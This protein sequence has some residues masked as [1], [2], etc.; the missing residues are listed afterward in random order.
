M[1][2]RVRCPGPGSGTQRRLAD[3]PVHRRLKF[4]EGE[5]G[6]ASA[7]AQHGGVVRNVEAGSR[8]RVFRRVSSGSSAPVE[9]LAVGARASVRP[10]RGGRRRRGIGDAQRRL[11]LLVGS[12]PG[13]GA[14]SGWPCSST[15]NPSSCASRAGPAPRAEA[16]RRCRE[17]RLPSGQL[18]ATRLR[19]GRPR[20]S[21]GCGSNVPLRGGSLTVTDVERDPRYDAE[22]GAWTVVPPERRSVA[23]PSAPFV[24]RVVGARRPATKDSR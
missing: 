22:G 14:T 11:A 6:P 18:A 17:V 13:R 8:R 16:G 19:T 9:V 4:P 23:G 1:A 12:G 5:H 7:L 21:A 24:G 10:A 3:P 15:A 20:F 2:R